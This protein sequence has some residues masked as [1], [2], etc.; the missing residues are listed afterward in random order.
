[1]EVTAVLSVSSFKAGFF[2]RATVASAIDRAR[3]A[4]LSK[5]GAF[6]RRAAKSSIKYREG[7]APPGR[8]PHA[9]TSAGFTRVKKVRGVAKRQPASPLRELIF[10][11]YDAAR[12]SVVSGP[13]LGGSKSG[14][15]RNLEEGGTAVVRRRNGR[16]QTVRVRPHPYMRPAL[17]ASLPKL[18][19]AVKNM[20]R[21]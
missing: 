14:A 13:A 5:I 7:A 21:R 1:L 4:A 3:K 12:G 15:P 11:A 17:R 19:A 8:P 10:F 9:H 2:D 20:I 18:P 16:F 6:V